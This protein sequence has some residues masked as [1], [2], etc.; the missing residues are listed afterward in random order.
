MNYLT[1]ENISKSY[2]EKMLFENISFSIN[3]GQKVAFVAKNGTGKST[4]LKIIAGLDKSDGDQSRII[5]PKEISIGYLDQNPDLHGNHTVMEA[6]Y[7]SE[8]PI[9][10]AIRAYDLCMLQP[11]NQDAVQKALEKMDELNAWDYEAKIKMILSKLNITKLDQLISSL[12]GGQQKRVAMAKILIKEPDFLIIDEP[13][14]HLDLEMI[15]WLEGFLSR[16]NLTLF[17]VTHDR[18]FLERVCDSI[19]ELDGGKI[20]KYNGNYSNYLEKKASRQDQLSKEVDSAKSLMRTELNWMRRQPKARG[21]KAKA[22]VDAFYNL[23]KK[24]NQKVDED[25]LELNIKTTR[26]G[27]KILELHNIVKQYDEIKIIEKFNYKFKKK[28]RVGIVGKN[29]VGKSTFLNML[30]QL[31][32]PDGGKVVKGETVLFGY[33]SQ[34]G[35]KLDGEKRVIDVVRDIAEFIPIDGKGRN[36]S[37]SMLLERFL[38]DKDHQYTY[39][40]KLSGGERRRLYLL[41][42][43]MT[44]PNFLILDEPTNDLDII[45]LNIL[46]EFLMDFKGCLVIVTHDRH[47]M[48]KLVDHLFV[49]EGEG[50]IKDYPGNYSAYRNWKSDQDQLKTASKEKEPTAKIEETPTADAPA[51]RRLNYN[52][53]M[54]YRNLENEIAKLEIKKKQITEKF[55]DTSLTNEQM[56][57]LSVELGQVTKSIEEKEDRWLELSEFA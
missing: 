51:K 28:D 31:E 57:A 49:F 52:E 25:R 38:F 30:L 36:I 27:S 35:I 43:L 11:D 48:D 16:Q 17:M 23:E 33:Y 44:N 55:N 37:A 34:D 20:Y 15:E 22:R 8:T 53:Q 39:V 6:V 26:L 32:Q 29:G 12:S 46:E 13:T 24:A 18:Y 4:M 14:N 19:V 9:I 56:T 5:I 54:E 50:K 45:T 1:V 41:T 3:K 21:T 7:D 47:F 42:I 40:H 2:G 10:H